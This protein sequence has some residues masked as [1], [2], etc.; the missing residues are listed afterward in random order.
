MQRNYR[1]LNN[2]N[3][4][5]YG[6]Q[7]STIV[8]KLA[9]IPLKPQT[10]KIPTLRSQWKKPKSRARDI[11]IFQFKAVPSKISQLVLINAL[12][13]PRP[14][15]A[16]EMQR[17]KGVERR[18]RKFETLRQWSEDWRKTKKKNEKTVD[19]ERRIFIFYFFIYFLYIETR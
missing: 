4:K 10:K 7:S 13:G 14:P 8:T 11:R 15:R 18:E 12:V 16:R 1:I 19:L 6:N 17:E 5:I 3:S 2:K 9:P